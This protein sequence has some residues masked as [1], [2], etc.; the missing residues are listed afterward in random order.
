[1]QKVITFLKT[2][3][4]GGALVVLPAWLAVLL[5]LKA[6]VHLQVLVKPVSKHLPESIGHPLYVAIALMIALCFLVGVGI[7]TGIGR[8]AKKAVEDLVLEKV[9]GYTTLRSVAEQIGDLQKDHGFK[10]ALVEIEDA[11]APGFIVEK[12]ESGKCTVFIPSAP[13]PMAGNIY[14]ID[15]ARVHPVD[16]PVTTMFK[17]ISKWGTGAGDLLAALPPQTAATPPGA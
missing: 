13:T 10:P 2:T 4:L 3:F 16:V 17:C 7:R 8:A 9:P 12:H 1:M 6:L 11:L 14:I 15:S 5:F